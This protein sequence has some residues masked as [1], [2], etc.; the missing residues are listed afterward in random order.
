MTGR[1]RDET[2][3]SADPE[4]DAN[5]HDFGRAAGRFRL[6]CRI[7]PAG[8]RFRRSGMAD[9]RARA[10]RGA[11]FRLPERPMPSRRPKAAS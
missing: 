11:A 1:R 2:R 3:G 6:F 7:R 5:L 4:K 9:C 8:D 10:G